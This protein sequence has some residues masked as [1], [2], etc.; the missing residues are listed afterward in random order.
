MTHNSLL[1][2]SFSFKI[3]SWFEINTFQF[4]LF[5]FIIF[6][7][8]IRTIWKKNGE[9]LKQKNFFDEKHSINQSLIIILKRIAK[10]FKIETVS[11]QSKDES[12]KDTW[13]IN[14]SLFD[15]FWESIIDYQIHDKKIICEFLL[16]FPIYRWIWIGGDIVGEED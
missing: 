4:Y 1:S 5:D 7:L 12:K 8:R 11:N 10:R 13:W 6:D 9:N 2:L 14:S 15:I 3:C 16:F